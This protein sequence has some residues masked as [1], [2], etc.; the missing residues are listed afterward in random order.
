MPLEPIGRADSGAGGTELLLV[1]GT[2]EPRAGTPAPSG[3]GGGWISGIDE[4]RS[5]GLTLRMLGSSSGRTVL[6]A[7]VRL[8]AELPAGSLM[9]EV[10]V[11]T[12][13]LAGWRMPAPGSENPEGWPVPGAGRL[14]KSGEAMGWL[15]MVRLVRSGE[16][17]G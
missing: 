6:V 9:L 17:I 11:P 16:P 1:A 12:P 15:V 13:L 8:K 3:G 14:V 2:A 7:E 10:V 5:G 4:P